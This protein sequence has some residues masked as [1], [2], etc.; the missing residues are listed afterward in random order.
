MSDD[1]NR[2]LANEL[3]CD[4]EDAAKLCPDCLTA[5]E[6]VFAKKTRLLWNRGNDMSEK[7]I[8]KLLSVH[9]KAT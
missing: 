1:G 8:S 9:M 4:I 3:L 7:Q 6:Y 2:E 5:W